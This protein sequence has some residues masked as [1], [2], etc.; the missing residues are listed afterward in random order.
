M[1]FRLRGYL[2]TFGYRGL[3]RCRVSG[4]EQCKHMLK[5]ER[6]DRK[7]KVG[8]WKRDS[9]RRRVISTY[10]Q[11]VASFECEGLY[12][13][14][15][16]ESVVVSAKLGNTLGS[17]RQ[18]EGGSDSAAADLGCSVGCRHRALRRPRALGGCS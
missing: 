4:A 12:S 1:R 9:P 5:H 17:R 13:P 8:C 15:V 2:R 14:L 7:Q 16:H 3:L 10:R 11:Y 18:E 6:C